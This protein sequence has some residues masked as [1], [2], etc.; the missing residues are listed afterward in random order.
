MA[1]ENRGNRKF[2]VELK[3]RIKFD[4]NRSKI[5]TVGKWIAV[6]IVPVL[7]KI[8]SHWFVSWLVLWLH[9]A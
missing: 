7:V 6:F 1:Q 3:V 8:A 9:L 4:E 2:E 5:V